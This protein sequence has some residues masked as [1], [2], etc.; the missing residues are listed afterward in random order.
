MQYQV[1]DAQTGQVVTQIPSQQMMNVARDI[2]K[3]LSEHS[4][5][6]HTDVK[7]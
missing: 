1:I 2:Q 6:A 7:G 5:E 4:A 3:F